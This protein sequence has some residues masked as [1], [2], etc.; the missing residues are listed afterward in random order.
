MRTSKFR[1]SG[2]LGPRRWL[3]TPRSAGLL[4]WTVLNAVYTRFGS[5]MRSVCSGRVMSSLTKAIPLL[6]YPLLRIFTPGGYDL[7][8]LR[9]L[10]PVA[11]FLRPVERRWTLQRAAACSASRPLPSPP[12][13]ALIGSPVRLKRPRAVLHHVG[14][15]NLVS[16]NL[17]SS[18]DRAPASWTPLSLEGGP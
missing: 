2:A 3:L 11:S 6:P 17:R 9:K 16:V 4:V 7:I 12:Q 15:P 14:V 8:P 1:T 10:T 5:P 13:I 18:Y